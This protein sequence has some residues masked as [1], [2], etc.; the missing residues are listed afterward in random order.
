MTTPAPPAARRHPALRLL[1][2]AA[3]LGLVA[4]IL[5][6]VAWIVPALLGYERYV[7]TGG[8]MSGSIERGSVAFEKT[9]PVEDLAVGDVITYL[10]PA[11]SGVDNLVTHRIVEVGTTEDGQRLFRTRGDANADPDPWQFSLTAPTQPVVEFSVP[12]VGYVFTAL[13][14]P[15]VRVLVIGVPAGLI[16]LLA[17]VELVRSV[18]HS[19]PVEH[20]GE[21]ST[22]RS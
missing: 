7:I 18:R 15:G 3:R 19:E 9:V 21:P 22:A 8:S 6:S 12:F 5:A 11:D 20:D 17:A 2:G 13:A 4:L 10:P 16:A 14:D 1:T